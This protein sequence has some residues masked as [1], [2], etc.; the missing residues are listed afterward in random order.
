M[1][2]GRVTYIFLAAC[3]AGAANAQISPTAAFSGA[4]HES[5]ESFTL[6][7]GANSF[8][9]MGNQATLSSTAPNYFYEDWTGLAGNHHFSL[10]AKGWAQVEQGGK[11]LGMDSSTF[12][13]T[14]IT[15]NSP[16][17]QFGGYWNYAETLQGFNQFLITVKLYDSSD[18]Q[19][20]TTQ[21]VNVPLVGDLLDPSMHWGGWTSTTPIAKVVY[22]GLGVVL[23]NVNAGGVVPEPAPIAAVGIG[24]LGLMRRRRKA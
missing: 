14:T 24:L 21:L 13:T 8:G 19:I 17:S 6:G 15:F 1:M 12:G 22:N 10:G 5:F 4:L 23:D 3:L 18:V 9:I 7:S 11:G 20:G 2:K 16:V